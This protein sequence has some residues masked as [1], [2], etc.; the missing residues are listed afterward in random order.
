MDAGGSAHGV[1]PEPSR[2]RR[3]IAR[4]R[5]RPGLARAAPPPVFCRAP[6]CQAAPRP[7][8]RPRRAS[9]IAARAERVGRARKRDRCTAN[10]ATAER[11]GARAPPPHR[12]ASRRQPLGWRVAGRRGAGGG[13]PGV[14]GRPRVA[15]APG[16]ACLCCPGPAPAR[17][18]WFAR[19]RRVPGRLALPWPRFVEAWAQ[20]WIRFLS[21]LFS[22][23]FR[24]SLSCCRRAKR[25]H[26][27]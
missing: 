5:L 15:T 25:T 11:R 21:V 20:R 6:E 17:A 13:R 9:P 3:R 16:L 7:S 14:A 1:E 19:A 27:V 2:R 24:C 22:V 8:A 18:A 26:G 12:H 10:P 4:G 23:S